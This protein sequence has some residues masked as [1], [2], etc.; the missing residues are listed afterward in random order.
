MTTRL[1]SSYIHGAG[2]AEAARLATLNRLLNAACLREAAPAPGD[3]IL[4]VGAGQGQLTRDLARAAGRPAV[5][6]FTGFEK[7]IPAG[8]GLI[9]F[10]DDASAV[11]A[12]RAVSAR[13]PRHARAARE[14]A[15]EYFDAKHLLGEMAAIVGL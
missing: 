10:A 7:F 11:E 8:D 13:Y 12:L 3:R 14:I 5:T 6:Q 15:R 2:A 9:G 4:D 1:E